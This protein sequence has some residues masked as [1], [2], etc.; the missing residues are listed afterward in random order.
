M[1]QPTSC[2]LWL[3]PRPASRSRMC[4]HERK[5]ST[6]ATRSRG[7]G[8]MM[9]LH[10][11]FNW[12]LRVKV[13]AL[14]FATAMVPL[15]VTLVVGYRAGVVQRR[16]MLGAQE[17]GVAVQVAGQIDEFLRS[18]RKLAGL[19]ARAGSVRT[20]YKDSPEKKKE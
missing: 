16:E 11:F 17:G 9:R 4:Y 15:V 18:Y 2:R 1:G 19:F 20:Y 14:L 13:L 8:Y 5:H 10:R 6:A 7:R 12:P 3:R